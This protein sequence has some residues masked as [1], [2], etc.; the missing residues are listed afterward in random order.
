[1]IYFMEL[2]GN[3]TECVNNQTSAVESSFSRDRSSWFEASPG[4]ADLDESSPMSRHDNLKSD[5]EVSGDKR[6]D[7]GGSFF[8]M[9]VIAAEVFLLQD[10]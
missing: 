4:T 10:N 7:G 5:N 6:E 8:E 3:T 1:M 9:F 2:C